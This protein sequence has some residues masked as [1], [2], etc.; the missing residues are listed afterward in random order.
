M[1]VLHCGRQH[2][3]MAVRCVSDLTLSSITIGEASFN[4]VACF[5]FSSR[6]RHT[7]WNC[8]WSSDVCSSDL[9]AIPI[10]L[11]LP[12]A[13]ML[14]GGATQQARVDQLQILRG[15]IEIGRA[16]CRERV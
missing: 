7:R 10:D 11:V 2:P 5:F 12:D 14:A 6:R 1:I 4:Q 3:A 13:L 16:S 15:G 8:D 9:Y